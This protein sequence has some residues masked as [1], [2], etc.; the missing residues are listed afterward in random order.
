MTRFARGETY[1][2][3]FNTGN[4][5]G[6]N[7]SKSESNVRNGAA[8]LTE[9]NCNSDDVTRTARRKLYELS[10]Y[11]VSNTVTRGTSSLRRDSQ[12]LSKVGKNYA[13]QLSLPEFPLADGEVPDEDSGHII[14]SEK[15]EEQKIHE[16]N[17][18]AIWSKANNLALQSIG[19]FSA[20]GCTKRN[21]SRSSGDNSMTMEQFGEYTGDT[22]ARNCT[23]STPLFNSR[24]KSCSDVTLSAGHDCQSITS[25]TYSSSPRLTAGDIPV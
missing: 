21:S 9:Q 12:L 18:D 4:L 11:G 16:K 8:G 10:D 15:E 3:Y 25:T 7:V 19:M 24:P 6:D 22:A 20:Q 5:G 2:K 14:P 23:H 17:H 13:I 1:R